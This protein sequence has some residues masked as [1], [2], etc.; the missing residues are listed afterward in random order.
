MIVESLPTSIPSLPPTFIAC[1]TIGL[2]ERPARRRRKRRKRPRW[3]SVAVAPSFTKWPLLSPL[4]P[5]CSVAP[6]PH[7]LLFLHSDR[8]PLGGGAMYVLRHGGTRM[9]QNTH[10]R[11]GKYFWKL[12]QFG[13]AA[14]VWP[15]IFFPSFLLFPLENVSGRREIRRWEETRVREKNFFPLL[16]PT[17]LSTRKESYHRFLFPL[18]FFFPLPCLFLSSGWKDNLHIP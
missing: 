12:F 15:A 7:P 4:L 14:K 5:L 18:P 13:M 17:H 1:A 2:H 9:R 3:G 11:F 8:V 6:S 10:A 16:H